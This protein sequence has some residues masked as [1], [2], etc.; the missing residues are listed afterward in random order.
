MDRGPRKERGGNDDGGSGKKSKS[1]PKNSI[2]IQDASGLSDSEDEQRDDAFAQR[3]GVVGL[4][5]SDDELA[6][7]DGQD[8]QGILVS[9]Y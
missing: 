2:A 8:E 1:F 4:N 5:V 6:S 7:D 3:K 9:C